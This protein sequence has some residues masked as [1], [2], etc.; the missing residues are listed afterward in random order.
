MVFETW[1]RAHELAA[2][3]EQETVSGELL[4]LA[5][6]NGDGLAARALAKS[7]ATPDTIRAALWLPDRDR[8]RPAAAPRADQGSAVVRARAEG[9]AL[10]LGSSESA[11]NLLLALLYDRMGSASRLLRRVAVD[12]RSVFQHLEAAGVPVPA[13]PPPADPA[14]KSDSVVLLIEDARFVAAEL[15]RVSTQEGGQAYFDDYGNARWAYFGELPEDATKGMFLAEPS[16]GL[17]SFITR[18]LRSAGRPIPPDSA[19]NARN[20]TES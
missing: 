19:W 18:A 16:L 12:R 4:L 14:E 17:R 11:E 8:T 1:A 3:L 5:L 13:Q 6:A 15:E 10:G 2:E 20:W 9:L 7:G